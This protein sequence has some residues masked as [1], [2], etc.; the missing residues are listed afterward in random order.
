MIFSGWGAPVMD[1]NFLEAAPNLRAVFYG[2]GS[3]RSFTTETFW[4]RDLV[5]TS[6]Y[7]ANAIPVAENTVATILLS[8]KHFWRM[9]GLAKRG[10]GWGDHS[11]PV[12]G[13]EWFFAPF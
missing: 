2:A 5:V 4:R 13:S 10:E 3:I 11:R 7:A 1:E 6:A 8:L 9:A 12:R